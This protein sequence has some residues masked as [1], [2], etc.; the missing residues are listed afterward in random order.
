MDRKRD[1]KRFIQVMAAL[2]E[3]FDAG[4]E[5][6]ALKSE[7]YFKS[8]DRFSIEEIELGA[9]RL[10]H[11]RTTATFPKPAEFIQEIQGTGEEKSIQAWALVDK[12]MRERGNY[13]S[14]DFGDKKIHQAI[15]MLGGWE[16]LGT[17]TE[18][19]WKWKHK[20]FKTLYESLQNDKG[21][22]Y[23]I[24]IDEK[25]RAE[26]GYK[27]LPPLKVYGIKDTKLLR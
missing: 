22:P 8:L 21:P 26:G 3:I 11:S 23:V 15:E 13:I 14:V 12:I 5:V 17:V 7:L 4:K 16:Y 1:R 2:S 20:E 18:D 6:S 25:K 27:A 24:G 10:I 19:E 9:Q